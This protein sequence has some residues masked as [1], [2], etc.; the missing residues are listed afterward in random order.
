MIEISMRATIS[1]LCIDGIWQI[2]TDR[3][4]IVIYTGHPVLLPGKFERCV[5]SDIRIKG[6]RSSPTLSV[7]L[8]LVSMSS[9]S[10]ISLYLCF[11]PPVC[12]MHFGIEAFQ[13]WIAVNATLR[14]INKMLGV[15]W[16]PHEQSHACDDVL[17][18]VV[19]RALVIVIPFHILESV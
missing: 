11:P 4:P 7:D 16:L 8:T 14:G 15:C 17:T 9:C 18:P 5:L 1:T 19:D 13:W 3:F 12:S 6:T 10:G 2:F